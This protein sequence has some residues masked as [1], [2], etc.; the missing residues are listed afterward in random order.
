MSFNLSTYRGEQGFSGSLIGKVSE[1][2]YI[3]GGIAGS[4][5]KGSTGARIG[6]SF[7]L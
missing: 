1:K 4:T 6:F 2:V 7:G 3:S 5:V